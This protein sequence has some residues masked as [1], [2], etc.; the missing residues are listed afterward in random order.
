MAKPAGF[1]PNQATTPSYV[2]LQKP[3]PGAVEVVLLSYT[4]R[5]YRL[6]KF[7]LLPQHCLS[8]LHFHSLGQHLVILIYHPPKTSTTFLSEPL[9][10]LTSLGS[11]FP[12]TLLLRDFSIHV[13]ST[14]CSFDAEFPSL[15]PL[16]IPHPLS[17][18]AVSS[19]SEP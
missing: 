11:K 19:P 13:D 10:L 15:L 4:E 3:V 1:T 8:V 18:P 2:Y 12:S 7:L 16:P 17:I 5:T 9:E 6:R 14:I